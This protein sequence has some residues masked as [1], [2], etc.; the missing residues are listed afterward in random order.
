MFE[1]VVVSLCDRLATRGEK[2]SLDLHGEA[3]PPG[4]HGVDGG[5]Q[6]PAPQLLS[7]DDVMALLGL[8]PGP[9][10]GRALDALEEE[11]EAGEVTDEA[12]ARAFLLEWWRASAEAP[13]TGP[14]RA[15][16]AAMPELPEVETVRRRLL[17]CLPGLLLREVVVNDWTVSVQTE[18]ELNGYL[19]G[20][21][22]TGLRRRG[23]YLLVDVG[24]EKRTARV[25]QRRAGPDGADPGTAATGGSGP[26]VAVD[27]PAHDRPAACS[28]PS[29]A[30]GRRASSGTS[31]RPPRCFFQDVRRF[32]RL[33][34]FAP[35]A[36]A[37]FFA[38][39]QMG[40]EPFGPDFTIEYLRGALRDRRA[41]LKA[42]LLDQRRIAG[43]GNIYADEALFRARLHPLRAAGSVGPREA[44]R[45][46][47]AV[48][49]TLQAGIDHEGSSIES[50][51]DPAGQRGSFQ[52]ILS[53][54]QRTGEPCRVCGTTVERVVVG[55]RGTHYCPRCQPR[56]GGMAPGS[57][58]QPRRD[59][60]AA[61]GQAGRLGGAG[62][63]RPGAAPLPRPTASPGRPAAPAAPLHRPHPRP[64]PHG[65]R[66]RLAG[67][68]HLRAR[69]VRVRRA[70][71][72]AA[73]EARVARHLAAREAAPLARR[74]PL[75]GLPAERAWLVD[76]AAGECELA[77]ALAAL[78]GA[79]RRRAASAP[80]TAAAPAT[81]CAFA[82]RPLR[83]DLA[84]AAHAA[85][86]PR[87]RGGPALRPPPLASCASSSSSAKAAV[88]P[89]V[90][91]YL[92]T[93]T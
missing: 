6:G 70:A 61:L 41:P 83:R 60:A 80:A 91:R 30:S 3:L 79:E 4:A 72:P 19:A 81:S 29:P 59:H 8:E 89:A 67:R 9:A 40:P 64:A 69:L 63:V 78:P 46:H 32:G 39:R 47:A 10:V 85:G 50:F 88:F 75:H 23:K 92:G 56:R 22:V 16:P 33:R 28:G 37:E 38:V 35:A 31:S 76:G 86:A 43:V 90:P 24:R 48:L 27:P 26:S 1:S 13:A 84:A 57:R 11:I 36:E 52:E 18:Q 55:G 74:L 54:Y 68:R 45:L 65:A 21:R 25:R 14:G 93:R 71:P 49:E 66:R 53:V 7:G 34:A 15:T 20:R 12:G 5:E 87:E 58:R 42:F 73:R 62:P 17:T 77:G 44:Q 2:T 51:I 82:R